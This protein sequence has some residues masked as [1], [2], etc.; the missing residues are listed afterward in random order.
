MQAEWYFLE[1]DDFGPFSPRNEMEALYLIY[2]ITNDLLRASSGENIEIL[3]ALQSAT[4]NKI[5][6][7]ANVDAE[8]IAGVISTGEAEREMLEWASKEGVK[9]K[10]NIAG[11]FRCILLY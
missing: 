9:S 8:N 7:F 11:E 6:F 4:V 5:K 10:L 3:H 2:S 1:D